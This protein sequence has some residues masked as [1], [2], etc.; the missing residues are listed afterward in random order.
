[1]TMELDLIVKGGTVVTGTDV[2]RAD[3]GVAG[4]KIAALGM[5]LGRAP[6]IVNTVAKYVLPGAIDVHTHFE[7]PFIRARRDQGR[8][9]EW[10]RQ[11]QRPRREPGSA[12]RQ[13]PSD[14]AVE[15]HVLLSTASANSGVSG[16]PGRQP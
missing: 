2:Y 8:R 14:R 12:R 1:M 7:M 4:G 16:L 11:L 10:H 13:V 15:G 6:R 5:D 3:V 9:E